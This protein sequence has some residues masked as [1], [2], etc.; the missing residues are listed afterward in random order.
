M[1]DNSNGLSYIF[2]ILTIIGAAV[3]SSVKSYQKA[4]QQR[5]EILSD[6]HEMEEEMPLPEELGRQST[7]RPLK[8]YADTDLIRYQQVT[9]QRKQ[10]Q[11]RDRKGER[12]QRFAALFRDET[13]EQAEIGG[14]TMIRDFDIKEAIIYS[15]II[16]RKYE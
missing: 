16:N 6:E 14:K 1:D 11:N 15:E 2:Y 13:Q 9:K 3:W 12:D 4:K 5:P 8:T 7:R 10:E